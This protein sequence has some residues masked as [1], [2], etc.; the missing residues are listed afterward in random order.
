MGENRFAGPAG[1]LLASD[2]IRDLYVGRAR[3]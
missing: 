3:S 2:E 1:D